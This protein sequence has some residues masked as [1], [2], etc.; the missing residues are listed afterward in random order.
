MPRPSRTR[1]H[2]TLPCSPISHGAP[3]PDFLYDGPPTSIAHH[4]LPIDVSAPRS[5][6][7]WSDL[8]HAFAAVHRLWPCVISSL[9]LDLS[10]HDRF[11]RRALGAADDRWQS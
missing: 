5:W 4:P 3:G 8:R 9:L 1:L 6:I 2:S 7:P 11:P 10:L